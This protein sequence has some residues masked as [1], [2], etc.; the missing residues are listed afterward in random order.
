MSQKIKYGCTFGNFAWEA[1]ATVDDALIAALLPL[2][3]LQIAQRTPS[4]EAEKAMAGYEKRPK[5]FQRNSIAFSDANADILQKRLTSI[6]VTDK[7]TLVNDK[8]TVVEYVPEAP[9]KKFAEAKAFL[10]D[11]ESDPQFETLV[12]SKLNYAGDTHGDDGEWNVE[13]LRIVD[14]RL[15]EQRAKAKAAMKATLLS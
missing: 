8:V 15:A 12:K 11:L 6:A 13:L 1:E 5:G 7:L 4:S 14:V 10:D 9:E 3:A 2:G